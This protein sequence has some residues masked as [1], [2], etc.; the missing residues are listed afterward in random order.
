MSVSQRHEAVTLAPMAHILIVD[1]EPSVASSLGLL[2]ERTGYR[3]TW[4]ADG[5][6][7]LE[8]LQSRNFDLVL[9]DVNLGDPLLDGLAV[10]RA[11]R[12][13]PGYTPVIMLTV[14]DG[15]T[16]KVI[17]LEVGADDYITKPY[18]ERE[19]L[20]R[21]R[22]TFRMVAAARAGAATT[23]LVIDRWLTIDPHRRRV[24]RDGAEVVL[25]PREFDLLVYLA[26]HA[27]QAFGREML[28]D[29]VWGWD[30]AVDTRTVDRHIAE[31]RR[32]LEPDPS[33]PR[34][35]LTVRGVGYAFR[36]W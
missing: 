1:D 27:G 22:A 21:I 11:I 9:L 23:P 34:Y 28:L 31:L 19:L 8:L 10:C 26:S 13:L 16:D 36:E 15:T 18:D 14:R 32:K 12:A 30:V 25:T 33:N 20:A 3:T 4:A 6:T 5:R 29:Q 35:I 17:G 2:L 24:L 7:A